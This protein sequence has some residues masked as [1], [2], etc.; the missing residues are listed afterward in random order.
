VK[1][2]KDPSRLQFGGRYAL[3]RISSTC[4]EKVD[5]RRSLEE[6]S[7]RNEIINSGTVETDES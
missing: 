3:A 7:N 1:D 6:S 2:I 5:V 4:V